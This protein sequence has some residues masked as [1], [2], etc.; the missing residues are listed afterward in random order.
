MST[1]DGGRPKESSSTSVLQYL[2]HYNEKF[3]RD[4]RQ[5]LNVVLV[6]TTGKKIFSTLFCWISS[7]LLSTVVRR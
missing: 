4:P 5:L 7:K 3:T 1:E 6:S 2:R